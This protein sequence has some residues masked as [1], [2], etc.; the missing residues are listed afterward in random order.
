MYYLHQIGRCFEGKRS[1]RF[2][3]EL[4]QCYSRD[5]FNVIIS[6]S[7]P[8]FIQEQLLR[9]PGILKKVPENVSWVH[10]LSTSGVPIITLNKP[11]RMIALDARDIPLERFDKDYLPYLGIVSSILPVYRTA[12]LV[13][14]VNKDMDFADLIQ[15]ID[16]FTVLYSNC[17]AFNG[18]ISFILWFDEAPVWPVCQ[19]TDIFKGY[20]ILYEIILI[21]GNET[22][23]EIRYGGILTAYTS[24]DLTLKESDILRFVT[25]YDP[26]FRQIVGMLQKKRRAVPNHLSII[27]E[28]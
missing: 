16:G 17:C 9:L 11:L 7:T 10:F 2:Y 19:I 28:F 14:R 24:T 27:G 13:L 4:G 18:S 15:V 23:Y 5:E 3:K 21:S 1:G 6:S 20:Y 8:R 26:K 22:L 12:I 25:I